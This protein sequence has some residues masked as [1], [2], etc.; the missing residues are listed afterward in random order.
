MKAFYAFLGKEAFNQTKASAGYFTSRVAWGLGINTVTERI[1]YSEPR[2]A[3]L[4]T[5]SYLPEFDRSHKG[6]V[7]WRN[8]ASLRG[9]IRNMRAA[10]RAIRPHY[11]SVSR[12]LATSDPARSVVAPRGTPTEVAL[13][14]EQFYDAIEQLR[15]ISDDT[16]FWD[17]GYLSSFPGILTPMERLAIPGERSSRVYWGSDAT[18]EVL[19]VVD[20]LAK[21][22][23]VLVW[24]DELEEILREALVRSGVPPG[25]MGE[26]IISVK[27]LA[28]P[29]LGSC[30]WSHK[31]PDRLIIC[32]VDN[33]TAC[34]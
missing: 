33:Q 7:S 9:S 22:V 25:G 8:V 19:M 10:T 3:R 2:V 32:P 31:Y 18:P 14:W 24:S 15:L 5:K 27:E 6:A 29:V 30:L 23:G 13:K 4:R 12:M 16:E 26:A 21:E 17:S 1:Y 28:A 11:R 34:A 20:H